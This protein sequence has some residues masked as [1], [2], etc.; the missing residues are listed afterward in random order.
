MQTKCKHLKVD[1]NE[2]T[3]TEVRTFTIK[4][5]AP[6]NMFELADLL[7][8]RRVIQPFHRH[9][10]RTIKRATADYLRAADALVAGL[11]PK[12]ERPSKLCRDLL[13]SDSVN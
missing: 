4:L 8:E 6:L 2:T 5:S 1:I 12:P 11:S 3:A 7:R 10:K 13:E 9:L